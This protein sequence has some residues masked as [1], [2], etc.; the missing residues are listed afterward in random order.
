[1]TIPIDLSKIRWIGG[2]INRFEVNGQGSA[3]TIL[4]QDPTA[5]VLI[6][7][8]AQVGQDNAQRTVGIQLHLSFILTS[9]APAKPAAITGYFVLDFI[10]TVDNLAELLLP[11]EGQAEPVAHPELVLT[12]A[13]VAYSTARGILW[14]RLAGTALD[15]ITLPIIHPGEL[16]QPAPVATLS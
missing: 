6:S 11:G 12:L 7:R 15:G 10:F 4:E 14:T 1:M 5:S 13:G 3:T 9:G 2:E 16:F 8:Q